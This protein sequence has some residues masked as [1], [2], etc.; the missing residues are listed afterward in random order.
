MSMKDL[1][2][3]GLFK[4]RVIETE[5]DQFEATER[6]IVSDRNIITEWM[7]GNLYQLSN[8]KK[9]IP[10]SVTPYCLVSIL[11]E[12]A[13]RVIGYHLNL[14]SNNSLFEKE[15]DEKDGYYR[16]FISRHSK[17][18]LIITTKPMRVI[19]LQYR[20]DK[21]NPLFMFDMYYEKSD[22]DFVMDQVLEVSS[23]KR[24]IHQ[25]DQ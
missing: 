5:V 25:T 8:L 12:D 10:E 16:F 17:D 22:F 1:F 15:F 18:K 20:F 21:Q 19:P 14:F 6:L 2:K 7:I 4:T 11:T 13:V 9:M 24:S 3:S 23:G